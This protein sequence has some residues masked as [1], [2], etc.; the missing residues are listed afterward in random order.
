MTQRER[1]G[2]KERERERAIQQDLWRLQ[3]KRCGDKKETETVTSV[4][5]RGNNGR[6][7]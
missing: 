3:S 7:K 2:E 1:E 4:K 5:V 6:E